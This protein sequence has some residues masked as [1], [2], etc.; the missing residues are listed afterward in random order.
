MFGRNTF[1]KSCSKYGWRKKNNLG[2]FR[3]RIRYFTSTWDPSFES[4]IL[5]VTSI[6]S[7]HL[8]EFILLNKI[9]NKMLKKIL[10]NVRILIFCYWVQIFLPC[11][12]GHITSKI[13]L[14]FH[15]LKIDYYY[16]FLFY[17]LTLI[18]LQLR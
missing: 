2:K 15:H 12:A 4:N 16:F 17:Q 8:F 13:I 6:R 14:N 1:Y 5:R 3:E 11:L 18:I 7:I 10:D 9:Q